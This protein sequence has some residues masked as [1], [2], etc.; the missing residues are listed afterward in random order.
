MFR[1]NKY[2]NLATPNLALILICFLALAPEA[3]GALQSERLTL[4]VEE[5][6]RAG[7]QFGV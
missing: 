2:S 7:L 6:G 1:Y 3:H 5:H 4:V